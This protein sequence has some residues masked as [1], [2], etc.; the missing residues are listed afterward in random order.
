M[1]DYERKSPLPHGP[2]AT[3][4]PARCAHTALSAYG[5]PG[6]VTRQALGPLGSVTSGVG[7]GS[8]ASWRGAGVVTSTPPR[9]L[10]ARGPAV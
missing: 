6:G 5:P 9:D 4:Q 10:S 2:L 8:A 1:D 3:A 7:W